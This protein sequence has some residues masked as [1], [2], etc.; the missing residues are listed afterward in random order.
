MTTTPLDAHLADVVGRVHAHFR[1]YEIKAR[2]AQIGARLI[3]DIQNG[4]QIQLD[5]V[6]LN[7]VASAKRAVIAALDADGDM[8]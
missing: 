7:M 2:G 1:T 6:I 3:G 5:H 4:I 8:P